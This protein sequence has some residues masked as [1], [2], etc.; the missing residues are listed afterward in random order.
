MN[1][2]ECDKDCLMKD[3]QYAGVQPCFY[4]QRAEENIIGDACLICL[5][6]I[7]AALSSGRNDDEQIQRQKSGDRR[8]RL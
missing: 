1:C 4:C 2:F 6:G 8:H 5:Q 7:C 3:K